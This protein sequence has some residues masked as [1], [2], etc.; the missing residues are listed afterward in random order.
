M[1]IKEMMTRSL[2]LLMFVVACSAEEDPPTFGEL[3][4]P[5]AESVGTFAV[6]EVGCSAAAVGPYTVVTA[7][8]AV[9]WIA[10]FNSDQPE[11]SFK[12]QGKRKVLFALVDGTS[13]A[14]LLFLDE[15]LAAWYPTGV[16][17]PERGDTVFFI[18]AYRG[19]RTCVVYPNTNPQY[20][21]GRCSEN[22]MPGD[23]GSPVLNAE[24]EVVGIASAGGADHTVFAKTSVLLERFGETP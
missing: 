15:P 2:L 9:E 8:H 22:G 10:K 1:T 11:V 24:G 6:S 16:G 7:A 21:N 5:A 3:P 14:A 13:D 19:V 20:F 12:G 18:S 23:S 4:V 17:E